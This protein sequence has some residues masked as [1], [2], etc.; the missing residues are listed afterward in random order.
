MLVVANYPIGIF[1]CLNSANLSVEQNQA[2]VAKQTT[3]LFQDQ[4]GEL[5]IQTYT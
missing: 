5:P 3:T 2:A 4:S 1:M